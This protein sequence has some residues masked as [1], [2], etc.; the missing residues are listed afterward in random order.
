MTAAQSA[1]GRS[2]RCDASLIV[3][4][5]KNTMGA[6][7]AGTRCGLL[8]KDQGRKQAGPSKNNGITEVSAEIPRESTAVLISNNCMAWFNPTPMLSRAAVKV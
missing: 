4:N 6:E 3:N 2:R 8:K 1:N 7:E 5:R